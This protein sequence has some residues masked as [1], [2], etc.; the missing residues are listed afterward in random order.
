MA[1]KVKGF[2]AA[3]MQ[4]VID[5]RNSIPPLPATATA[6]HKAAH[7]DWMRCCA[8]ALTELET[9]QMFAVRALFTRSNAGV[10]D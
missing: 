10:K 9:G 2:F 8:T 7:G 6:E 4:S 1:E 5:V 3:S